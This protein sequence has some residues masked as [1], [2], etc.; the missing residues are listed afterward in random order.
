MRYVHG[1]NFTPVHKFTKAQVKAVIPDKILKYLL[2]KVYDNEGAN[3]NEDPS[4]FHR[5][6]TVL[7]WKKAWSWFML[8][9]MTPWSDVA[10]H[11]NPTKSAH[12]NR[13]LRAMNKMEAARR[14]VT[15]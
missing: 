12:I 2:K 13:L 7:Y 10:K 3:H 11:G 14:G 15:L 8:D 6:N 4:L 5:P 9:N 1:R